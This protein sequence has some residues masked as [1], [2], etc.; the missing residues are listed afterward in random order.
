VAAGLTVA[1]LLTALIFAPMYAGWETF[2]ALRRPGMTFILSPATLLHGILAGR[3]T[4]ADASRL[5]R[6]LTGAGFV[7]LYLPMVLRTRG[8]VRDLAARGFDVLFAYLLLASWWFW[9]WYLTWLAPA[10][11]VSRG[12]SRPVAFAACA[13]A[14]LL[15]YIYWWPD[16]VW[17]STRWL[18]AYGAITVGVFLVPAAIWAMGFTRRPPGRARRPTAVE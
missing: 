15:T 14:A 1:V 7:A 2:A 4:E 11:A 9:P 10:A 17:R 5:A 8:D 12:W 16:P 18:A 13:G 3:L 6:G